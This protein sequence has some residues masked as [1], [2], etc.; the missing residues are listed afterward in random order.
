MEMTSKDIELALWRSGLLTQRAQKRPFEIEQRAKT[1]RK[2]AGRYDAARLAECNGIP[3][4]DVKA[5]RV[6]PSLTE[7]DQIDLDAKIEKAQDAI[8]TELRAI[9]KRGTKYDF[10]R[11]PRAAVMR[12]VNRE[13]TK[14]GWIS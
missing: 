7:Q 2:H 4:Y 9:L 11:D 1:I 10:R 6:L 8:E 14:D 13:N 5:G 3:R 12:F